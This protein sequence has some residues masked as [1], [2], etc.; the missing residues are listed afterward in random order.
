MFIKISPVFRFVV[1][2]TSAETS[3]FSVLIQNALLSPSATKPT[4]SKL[5]FFE[6]IKRQEKIERARM[7]ATLANISQLFFDSIDA[8]PLFMSSTFAAH[9]LS[10][11]PS[12]DFEVKI[13]E[14]RPPPVVTNFSLLIVVFVAEGDKRVF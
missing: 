6:Y 1:P 5:Q 4:I 2:D 7:N 12:F 8:P 13:E 3:A 10:R 11:S 14:V 9:G